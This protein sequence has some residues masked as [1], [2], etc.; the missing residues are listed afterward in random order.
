MVILCNNTDTPLLESSTKKSVNKFYIFSHVSLGCQNPNCRYVHDES[1]IQSKKIQNYIKN[2]KCFGGDTEVYQFESKLWKLDEVLQLESVG[3]W[4]PSYIFCENG[5]TFVESID[6]TKLFKKHL[7][8]DG[9]HLEEKRE[10]IKQ[11]LEK[12]DYKNKKLILYRTSR[13]YHAYWD[14][15]DIF[16]DGNQSNTKYSNRQKINKRLVK[17]K[18]VSHIKKLCF[19]K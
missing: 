5:F 4:T 14:N 7:S 10:Y 17:E 6:L 11:V 19:W 3:G 15:I 8:E 12:L 9:H 16:V 13:G 18:L 2:H 1:D